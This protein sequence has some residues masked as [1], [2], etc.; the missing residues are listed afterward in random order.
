MNWKVFA[1]TGLLALGLI[2][3]T[4]AAVPEAE[5]LPAETVPLVESKIPAEETGLPQQPEVVIAYGEAELFQAGNLKGSQ[6]V[7][8]QLSLMSRDE[9]AA[10][11]AIYQGLVDR[12][13][14]I[15]LAEYQLTIDALKVL[16]GKVVNDHPELFYV[17]NEYRYSYNSGNMMVVSIEPTYLTGLPDDAEERM[18]QA[19]EQAMAQVEAGM[20][21]MEIALILHDYLVEHVAYNWD[22]ATGKDTGDKIIHSAYGALV[23]GDAVCEGYAL[24]YKLLLSE[25]G[26]E[27]VLVTSEEM[28]HA[29][30]LV[31]ID[32]SW[33]H[34]DVTWDDPTPD[35]PGYCGHENFLRSDE[36]I[37]G[38]KHHDWTVSGNAQIPVS[39]D[40]PEG[41]FRETNNRMYRYNGHYYYLSIKADQGT[42]CQA[43]SINDALSEEVAGNLSFFIHKIPVGESGY[44]YYPLYSVIW[45][46]GILYYVNAE[47]ELCRLSLETYR[48]ASLGDIPFV[49]GPSV[50]QYYDSTQ[51]TIALRYDGQQRLVTAVSKTRPDTVFASFQLKSYPPDWDDASTDTTAIVGTAWDGGTLQIGLVWARDFDDAPLLLAAFYQKNGKLLAVREITITDDLSSGLHVLTLES[52]EIP[53]GY[54]RASL[55]LLDGDRALKPLV[56]QT[57]I[58]EAA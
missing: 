47:R 22:V 16:F 56:Q 7:P 46:D 19:T 13:E 15:N 23:D 58:S 36:G 27:S 10:Y 11:Q 12:N 51:D 35:L 14:Q 26:V 25:C 53:D 38:T 39:A 8:G 42:L 29:W 44:S 20:S 33:Y 2:L 17:R 54:T 55:F 40:E 6:T 32:G 4:A 31:E 48:S 50:D 9:D 45:A 52:S 3:P 28:N 49:A 30:N 21:D 43:D 18:K 1:A 24:A 41:P 57:A 37:K 5:S 34:V